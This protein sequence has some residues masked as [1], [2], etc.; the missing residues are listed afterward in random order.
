[1]LARQ[2]ARDAP[3]AYGSG[4]DG[5]SMAF[6]VAES[7]ET[8]DHYVIVLSV[9]PQ[10]DF[11]GRPGQGQFFLEKIGAVAHRHVLALPRPRR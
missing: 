7:E 3:G 2:T 1:M 8:E 11:S 6:D 4:F 9:R 10:G 5:V